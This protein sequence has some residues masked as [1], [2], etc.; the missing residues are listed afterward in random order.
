MSVPAGSVEEEYLKQEGCLAELERVLHPAAES[1]SSR[2]RIRHSAS[3]SDAGGELGDRG[4]H[5]ENGE[6][7]EVEGEGEETS[8]ES[9]AT[10]A[11]EEEWRATAARAH[12]LLHTMQH[13]MRHILHRLLEDPTLGISASQHP[14]TPFT[15]TPEHPVCLH[16]RT[17]RLLARQNTPYACTL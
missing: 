2:R 11:S 4:E 12:R 13:N 8:E 6:H 14:N 3:R 1:A 17:P 16:A 5:G 10:G 7:E 15:C 9:E